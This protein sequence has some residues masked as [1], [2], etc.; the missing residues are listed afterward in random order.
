MLTSDF[1][2]E[3][4]NKPKSP[5]DIGGADAWYH[6]GKHPEQFDD[7]KDREE[8]LRGYDAEGVSGRKQGK[9]MEESSIPAATSNHASDLLDL[10]KKM[11]EL[12]RV[13]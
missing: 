12:N 4:L 10:G 3:D 11:V 13:W 6:R 7:A 8:Y 9:Q 2:T 5:Y 1:F